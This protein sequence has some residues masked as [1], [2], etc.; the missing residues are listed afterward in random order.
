MTVTDN[1]MAQWRYKRGGRNSRLPRVLEIRDRAEQILSD[2]GT[3]AA[4]RSLDLNVP[5]LGISYMTPFHRHSSGLYHLDIWVGSKMLNIEWNA[6]D[7][8]EIVSFHRGPWEDL[9]LG[10]WRLLPSA[11]KQGL[12]LMWRDFK[13]VS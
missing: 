2:E 8:I 4:D 12:P 10:D 9:L 3:F 7:D 5:W 1:W 13:N 6:R 11:A